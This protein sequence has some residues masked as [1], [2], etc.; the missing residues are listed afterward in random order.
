MGR[1]DPIAGAVPSRSK[2]ETRPRQRAAVRLC[3]RCQSSLRASE[4]QKVVFL[5]DLRRAK[6][7]TRYICA[8]C[9]KDPAAW[10]DRPYGL[11]TLETAY[12]IRN[13]WKVPRFAS[14]ALPS[15]RG[16]RAGGSRATPSRVTSVV[17]GGLPGLGK[18]S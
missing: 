1:H 15:G 12:T 7:E 6:L 18:R 3:V 14:S 5:K 4:S 11:I 9:A 17:S 13:K 10:R 8:V 16:R 2:R